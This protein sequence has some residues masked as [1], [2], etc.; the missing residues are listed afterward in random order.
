[1]DI[2]IKEEKQKIRI[3]LKKIREDI[4]LKIIDLKSKAIWESLKTDREYINA[5]VVMF[6]SSINNEVRTDFMIRETLLIGKKVV[7]PQTTPYALIPRVISDYPSGLFPKKFGI[8]E[9]DESFPIIEKDKIDIVVVPGLAFS[10][11]CSRLGYGKGYYDKF[12]KDYKGKKIG[13][14]FWE[15]I[16]D[17]LPYE[18]Y[19]VLLDKIITDKIVINCNKN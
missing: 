17:N 18:H 14:A 16:I 5:K 1:M 9:P 6:Y 8:L 13:V 15:Q 10:K 12:L 3:K 2:S 11:E 19:D 4:P 7:L